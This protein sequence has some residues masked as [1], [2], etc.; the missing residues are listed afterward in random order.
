MSNKTPI[1]LLGA[2][3]EIPPVL[4]LPSS[5]LLSTFLAG[6]GYIGG[7][8]LARLFQH[9]NANSFEITTIVRSADKADILKSK[10]GANA[11]VGTFQ[12]LD[13]IETLAENAHVVLHPVSTQHRVLPL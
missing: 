8:V 13:K 7:A 9:A 1:F 10:F 5:H 6:P 2:T 4:S 3:G 12:D 11:V